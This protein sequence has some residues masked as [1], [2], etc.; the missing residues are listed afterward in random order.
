MMYGDTASKLF[1]EP[2]LL[3]KIPLPKFLLAEGVYELSNG[4]W[5]N[6]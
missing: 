2:L 3:G 5:L 4:F 6:Q 1:C